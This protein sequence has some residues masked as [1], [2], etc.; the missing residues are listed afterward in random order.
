MHE[1]EL[2][3]YEEETIITYI[4]FLTCQVHAVDPMLFC[5]DIGALHSS[6]GDKA[7]ERIVRHYRCRSVP[8]IDSKGDFKFGD[9]LV[10][11]RGVIEQ[12]LP[13]PESTFDILVIFDVVDVE[14]QALQGLDVLDGNN[15]LVYN[16]TNYL[17][18]RIIN[19]KDPLWFEDMW[20]S[21]L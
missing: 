6:I 17:W 5:V 8:V 15:H 12:M 10:R 7:L 16:V 9:T 18:N 14:I 11:S 20:K 1:H 19:N 2:N 13:T 4:S 21:N 3:M